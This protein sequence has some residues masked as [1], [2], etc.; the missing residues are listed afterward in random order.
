MTSNF[1]RTLRAALVVTAVVWSTVARAQETPA[2][3]AAAPVEPASALSFAAG[4]DWLLSIE[5][6]F[7][8]TYAHQSNGLH[9]NTFT[10]FGDAEGATKSPY[11]YP[12]LALDYMV[13]SS[14]SV[15]LVANFVRLTGSDGSSNT[16][17]EGG[18]RVGYAL[19][20]GTNF[21]IWPRAGVTYS[22]GSAAKALGAT[23]EGLLVLVI[24][25]HLLVTVGPVAD[26]GITGTFKG[27]GGVVTDVTFTD[28]GL[29][30]GLTVPL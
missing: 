12:S 29:Y 21:G 25:P 2:A 28:I 8:Y 1:K 7:G 5:N 10:L 30:F 15:G 27:R 19:M 22:Y 26:I 16:G 17:F 4:G 3:P 24:T 18:L 23:I 20:P 9:A 14:I 13:K 6:L 11:R